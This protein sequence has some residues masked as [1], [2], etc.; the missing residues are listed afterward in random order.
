LYSHAEGLWTKTTGIAEH[1]QG[2][3]NVPHTNAIHSIGIG[4]SE[5]KRTN[6]MTVLNN[7]DVYIKGIGDYSGTTL[8]GASTLQTVVGGI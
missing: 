7:G 8:N 5:S 4:N 2:K 3:Y 6:A 1:A